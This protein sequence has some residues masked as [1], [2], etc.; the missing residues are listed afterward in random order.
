MKK[1]DIFWSL[2]LM[3]CGAAFILAALLNPAMTHEASIFST[4][5]AFIFSGG[6]FF[7]KQ[8]YR[9]SPGHRE[10]YRQRLTQERIELNDERKIM[11]RE[12]SGQM[13]YGVSLVLLTLVNFIF[14]FAGVEKWVILTLWGLIMV[15]WLSGLVL[16]RWLEKKY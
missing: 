2:G 9:L 6:I 10:E 3:L 12:K 7:T 11:L 1:S 15:Q 16:Y 14:T 5:I 4:G 13:A 8:L